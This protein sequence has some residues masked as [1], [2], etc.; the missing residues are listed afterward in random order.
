MGSY[1]KDDITC[2]RDRFGPRHPAINVK[3][4]QWGYDAEQL[5]E[6][7]PALDKVQAEA[8][9]Q[10]VYT[11][12][13]TGFWDDAQW[14][15]EELWGRGLKVYQEGRSGGWLVVH[16]LPDVDEWDGKMLMKWRSLEVWAK[17]EVKHRCSIEAIKETIGELALVEI[18]TGVDELVEVQ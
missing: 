7:E 6:D 17:A 10:E 13:A 14:K 1:S 4:R 5:M 3:V 16:G 8:I 2:H 15:V 11:V 18:A 12:H 9:L